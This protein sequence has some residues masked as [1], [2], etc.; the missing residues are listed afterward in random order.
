MS[1]LTFIFIQIPEVQ[2]VSFSPADS[3]TAIQGDHQFVAC[4]TEITLKQVYYVQDAHHCLLLSCS[5][6]THH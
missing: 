2:L 4:F 3:Y 5:R 6:V 1:S